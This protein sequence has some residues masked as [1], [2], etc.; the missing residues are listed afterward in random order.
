MLFTATR[1]PG[2]DTNL[3]ITINFTVGGTAT[4]PTD[5]TVTGAATFTA[6]NGSL[7]IPIGQTFASMTLTPIAD[8]VFEADETIVLTP[9]AQSGAWSI[10]S[11]LPLQGTILNDDIYIPPPST[12]LLHFDGTN[13]STTIVDSSTPPKTVTTIGSTTI[14]TAQSKFGGSSLYLPGGSGIAIAD[15]TDLE[16]LDNDF[17]IE[18]FQNFTIADYVLG[19]GDAATAAGSSIAWSYAYG[20]VAIYCDGGTAYGLTT[21]TPVSGSFKHIAFTRQAGILRFFIEG[22][23]TNSATIPVTASINNTSQP[24]QFGAYGPGSCTGFADELA[25][26]I[27]LCRY[28]ANFTPPTAARS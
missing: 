7:I 24:L 28:T 8:L 6:T 17:T 19:K 4:Y 15:T 13:G 12:L 21:P 9:Q 2:D 16:F 3:P 25:I 14:S 11:G 5:Y 22:M 1:R 26:D 20:S 23:L 10:G 18:W 27:G